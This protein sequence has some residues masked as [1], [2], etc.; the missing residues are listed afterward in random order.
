MDQAKFVKG[1]LEK[2][3]VYGL[4]NHPFLKAVFYKFYLPLLE[5]F[6]SYYLIL[7]KILTI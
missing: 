4:L 6:V 7:N 3:K 1:N 5:Y 2:L